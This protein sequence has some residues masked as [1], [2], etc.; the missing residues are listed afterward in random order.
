MPVH[1]N[2]LWSFIDVAQHTGHHIFIFIT[3][4]SY[5]ITILQAQMPALSNNN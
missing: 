2:F 5:N 1:G 3:I 4:L